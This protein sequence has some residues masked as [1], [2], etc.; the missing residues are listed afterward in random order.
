[1]N[2]SIENA[3]IKLTVAD[4]GAEMV[5]L[6]LKKTGT[7]YIWQADPEYWNGHAYNLFPICGRLWEGKYTYQGRTYEMNLHG[8]AR[9]TVYEMVEQTEN[10]LTFELHDT[11]TTLAIYPF[12]FNLKLIYTIEG[13]SVKT[14]FRLVN[15]DTKEVIYAFG[16]HPGFNVPLAEGENFTDYTISFS[17]KCEPKALC[18]SD[19]CYYLGKNTPFKL[20]CGKSFKLDHSLFDNDAIFL[21]DIAHEVTLKSGISKHFVT[22]SYPD[23][24]FLGFWHKPK[25]EAPYVCI[26]PWQSVP[27]DDGKIDD[28]ETKRYM[29]RLPAGETAESAIVITIG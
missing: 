17:E 8:F 15:T 16:G 11:E 23:M 18:M 10:S 25:T 21:T 7:E 12:R 2:Y 9:K 3:K 19:T 28:F 29:R 5:S 13:A 27:A 14:T 26:E 6:I 24:D 22:V 1:M 4:K 20:R